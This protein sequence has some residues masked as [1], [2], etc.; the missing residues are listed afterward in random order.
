MILIIGLLVMAL[1]LETGRD[2]LGMI[3]AIIILWGGV[4]FYWNYLVAG[5]WL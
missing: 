3:A 4:D 2:A 5:G 1:W